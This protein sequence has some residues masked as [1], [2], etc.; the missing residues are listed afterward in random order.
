MQ[1]ANLLLSCGKDQRT[2]AWNP[3]TAE[4]IAE[5]R[6]YDE[7]S[8]FLLIRKQAPVAS[9]WAFQVEWCPR[10]PDLLAVASFDGSI[11]IH[12]LQSTQEVAPEP[13]VAGS[14][15]DIFNPSYHQNFE[16]SL[17][18]KQPPKWLHRPVSATFG[19]GGT[20]VTV[21]NL[22]G[23]S[24]QNQSGSV[25]IHKVVTEN[26]IV[27]Q[28]KKLENAS[29]DPI[30]LASLAKAN[31]EAHGADKDAAATWSALA[32]LF[33]TSSKDELIALLGFSKD[34]IVQ[35]VE[36]A[37]KILQTQLRAQAG[38]K[39]PLPPTEE[40]ETPTSHKSSTV[41]FDG[42]EATA[43]PEAVSTTES[44]SLF[45]DEVTGTPAAGDASADF[46]SSLGSI[47]SA[48]PDHLRVPHFDPSIESSVAATQGSPY[49][50]VAPSEVLK[51]HTF[52]IY[53]DGES[54]VDR[55]VTKALVLGD[56]E[57]AVTLCL[58]AE[59][60]TD[61]ILLATKGGPELL[62]KTQAAYFERRTISPPYLRLFQSIVGND[63]AD[64]VQ[65]ADLKEWQVIFVILC[66]YAPPDE[67]ATLVEQLGLRLEFQGNLVKTSGVDN[68]EGKAEHLRKHAT[69][70][71]LAAGRLEKVVNIWVEEMAEEEESADANAKGVSRYTVHAE[72][73]QS[74]IEK[75]T[76]FRAAVNYVDTEMEQPTTS[77]V[78]AKTG[79]RMYKLASLY[80]RYFE[81]ADLLVTQGLV[82]LAVK[83]LALTP[84]DYKG[85]DD[86]ESVFEVGRQRLLVA[87]GQEASTQR[88]TAATSTAAPAAPSK[89]TSGLPP[90]PPYGYGVSP[91][92]TYPGPTPYAPLRGA[93][94]P[95]PLAPYAN[96][97]GGATNSGYA[98][99]QS[100]YGRTLGP[101]APP[102]SMV[103]PP[104]G[105]FNTGTP[106]AS[107]VPTPSNSSVPLPAAQ[108]K[109]IPG[110]NDAPI[111]ADKKPLVPA[112]RPAIPNPFPNAPPAPSVPAYMQ[113][114]QHTPGGI[115]PPP[116]AG[117]A[118]DHSVPPPPRAGTIPPPAGR[119]LGSSPPPA[120]VPPPPK[121]GSHPPP[122]AALPYQLPN[123]GY[124][125][126]P[127]S[128]G[129]PQNPYGARPP[130]AAPPPATGPY[131][132]RPGSVGPPGGGLPPPPPASAYAPPPSNAAPSPYAPPPQATAQLGAYA[133]PPSGGMGLSTPPPPAHRA[134]PP[135][136][137]AG[138][139]PTVRAAPPPAAPGGSPY[140]PPP[141]AVSVSPPAQ[142]APA[143]PA[144]P[145]KPA[146][147]KYREFF[148]RR[149]VEYMLTVYQL[150]EI[151]HIYPIL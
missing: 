31:S 147:P 87:A 124:G 136:R 41:A 129:P 132:P 13:P 38:V 114:A 117:S 43:T 28:A 33:D 67:F 98:P 69:L 79:A 144:P 70:C 20:L 80:D 47:P 18:L 151:V 104:A 96:G 6:S 40:P 24:G 120:G 46:F 101:N 8:I 100:P 11:G 56:F 109:D 92:N 53:P 35:Q 50:S 149:S 72:A 140:A 84:K 123:S 1:D 66:T 14:S 83:Y 105:F 90:M 75:V 60:F 27:S 64:I 130:S 59:R 143:Q 135:P 17:C 85:T 21:N 108:R 127:G 74:F 115:H 26:N 2:L 32:S 22:P 10:N 82:D 119:G 37:V 81:Y 91:A 71:Y 99:Y 133:H 68:A 112:T 131:A 15:D 139:P 103:P 150:P 121:A 16:S 142:A 52:N 58:S 42:L 61:A 3:D 73:L 94:A 19:Y 77:E 12:S 57:S 148:L 97:Y 113:S 51:N 116:R 93:P 5:V 25:H 78:V 125:P 146:G 36:E 88:P 141:E 62:K 30:A 102:Q 54:N 118:A 55:L 126:R 134:P 49:S 86:K 9:N 76:I 138:A 145:P 128:A 110:W 107:N 63:L 44:S 39:S 65:N 89:S 34:Q 122:P 29:S 106:P 45:G 137:A 48:I 7:T 95:A 23:V 4:V 111:V